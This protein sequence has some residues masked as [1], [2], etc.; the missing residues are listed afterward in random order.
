MDKVVFGEISALANKFGFCY[1]NNRHFQA[2]LGCHLN[3]LHK[4]L[5][6]LE[7]KGYI[8]NEVKKDKKGTF[9]K[10]WIT[11]G[12]PVE[13]PV[14]NL[15]KTQG[16]GSKKSDTGDYKVVIPKE[17]T[18]RVIDILRKITKTKPV[19]GKE[20]SQEPV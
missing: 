16:G 3:T 6:R 17:S 2:I 20:G 15:W 8:R 14:D 19:F 5:K 12:K 11:C 13:N 7:E 1:A 4:S 10:L 18:K 9:R